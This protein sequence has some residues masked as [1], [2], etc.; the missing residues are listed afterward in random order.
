MPDHKTPGCLTPC[1]VCS[2]LPPLIAS[3]HSI[4]PLPT[5]DQWP[6]KLYWSLVNAIGRFLYH[7]SKWKRNI[8]GGTTLYL[9]YTYITP[10]CIVWGNAK[11]HIY[12]IIDFQYPTSDL[13]CHVTKIA[14]HISLCHIK[15][16]WEFI[17]ICFFHNSLIIHGIIHQIVFEYFDLYFWL[18]ITIDYDMK[19]VNNS[20][21]EK[22]LPLKFS[23]LR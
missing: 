22:R 3:I 19:T 5:C 9:R 4:V 18:F 8:T 14:F 21:K 15:Q 20:I 7:T 11:L 6:Q 13:G 10:S 23:S 17:A 12:C 16:H 1:C 2:H